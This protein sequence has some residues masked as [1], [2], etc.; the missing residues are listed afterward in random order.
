MA[1]HT[2]SVKIGDVEIT[3]ET[4]RLA[5]Q[6]AG[7]A[8]VRIGD[9]MILS[10][11]CVGPEIEGQDF[12][13]LTVEY[14]E[15]A[16]AAGKIPGGFL[17]RESK[18]SDE[19]VLIARIID[20]PIRPLF[21]DGYAREV[22]IVNTVISADEQNAAN[23]TG[24]IS[25]SF[26]LCISGLPFNEPVAGVNV[27]R[28]DGKLIVFP[29]IEQMTKSDLELV[30]AGTANS[31]M[32]V[33][34]GAYEVPEKELVEAI[35]FAHSHIKTLVQMQ[36]DMLAEMNIKPVDFV[37]PE[38][39]NKEIDADVKKFVGNRLHEYS[40]M[41]IKHER[42][43]KVAEL[44]K[45]TVAALAEKYP[46][47]EEDIKAAYEALE[48]KDMRDTILNERVRIGGRKLDQV[49]PIK[50]ELDFLPR[51]HGSVVFTRGETQSLA[52][53]TL[54]TKS[55]EKI[56]D[57]LQKDYRKT[58]YLH[59]NFPAYSVGECKRFG[60]VG[61]REVG[62]G[63]L[64]ERALAPMI[65][66]EQH[67]PYTVRLVSEIL[68]S[69]GSSSMAS[70][71]GGSLALMAAGVPIK[72]AVAGVAMGLIK[73]GDKTAI[74]TDILGTEDHLG[75]MDFKV[76]GTGTGVTAIQMDIKID[77]ITPELMSEALAQARQARL[78]IL[79]IMNEVISE[80]RSSVSTFAPSILTTKIAESKIG[81][82]IGPGGKNI[83][84]LQDA[85]GAVVNIAE[86]GTVQ[87]SGKTQNI[88]KLALERIEAQ[89]EDPEVGR[90][91]TA[92]VKSIVDFGAFVEYLP[93]KEGLVHISE[94]DD[95][96]VTSVND[97]LKEGD[98]VNVKLV[99]M[100]KGKVRL[101]IK[102]AKE[103]E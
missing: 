61:R 8:T 56:I 68:E 97:Y 69:N 60:S 63:H 85:T 71:C 24:V 67:F 15:K 18:P 72:A 73:E 44:K 40:F 35:M 16:Y 29:T 38:G 53:C 49:R 4:G 98:V 37:A 43:G 42:Y 26:A 58:Y 7:S 95:K 66:G 34:G 79:N 64:A 31:I 52:V 23:V 84:A 78:H 51:A 81:E 11:V 45:E 20:R 13:P 33:E 65:P 93:G 62:H 55:D 57:G 96:R 89:M 90:T 86:D 99:G 75:D 3:I 5:K 36:K 74:L 70:V 50:I 48:E 87:I 27:G 103:L 76:T 100:D 77:G 1:I 39:R 82:L 10:T 19:E 9:S 6:A 80:P 59:Y 46:E 21:P 32:M 22:Q 14:I 2:K 41:G 83:K 91:Y 12:F 17:K 28:V 92:K 25:S 47:Q 54:G 88:A 94:L 30:V 101:S 102:A